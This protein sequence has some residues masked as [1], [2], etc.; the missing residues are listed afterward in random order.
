MFLISYSLTES[1]VVKVQCNVS[2]L[3]ACTVVTYLVYRKVDFNAIKKGVRS[4]LL[5]GFGDGLDKKI[6]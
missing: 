1:F 3:W 4:F 6:V 5:I 2:L